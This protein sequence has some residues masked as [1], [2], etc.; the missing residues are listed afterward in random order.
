MIQ[1]IKNEFQE[2]LTKLDKKSWILSCQA[3]ILI[4]SVLMFLLYQATALQIALETRYADKLN[5][6]MRQQ[7]QI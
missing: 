4:K 7:R 1:Q 2:E 3:L 5:Q 6:E